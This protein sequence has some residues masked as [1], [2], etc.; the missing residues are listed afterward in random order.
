M[1]I[2]LLSV[3]IDRLSLV[4]VATGSLP[5]VATQG[6]GRLGQQAPGTCHPFFAYGR[7]SAAFASTVLGFSPT[8]TEIFFGL[9]TSALGTTT[10]STPLS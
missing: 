10:S 4:I 7:T 3:V 2:R 1:G 6:A 5:P 9:A 8:V